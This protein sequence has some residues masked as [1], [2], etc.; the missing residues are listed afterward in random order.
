MPPAVKIRCA[1]ASRR[2]S[3]MTS[4]SLA[5]EASMEI[6]LCIVL[7]LPELLL[8]C[9]IETKRADEVKVDPVVLGEELTEALC[10]EIANS[11]QQ[12]AHMGNELGISAHARECSI[13]T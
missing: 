3:A 7:A 10:V 4:V 8:W 12:L 5:A 1:L 9:N 11:K 13:E 6:G 2:R